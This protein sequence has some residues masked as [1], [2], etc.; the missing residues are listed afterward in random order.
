MQQ[1][2]RASK[3]AT[4]SEDMSLVLGPHMVEREKHVVLWPFPCAL[5]HTLF[6]RKNI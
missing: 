5:A 1:R 4:E 3:M 2:M 6:P